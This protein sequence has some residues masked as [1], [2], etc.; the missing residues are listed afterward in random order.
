MAAMPLL[1]S[2]WVTAQAAVT[3]VLPRIFCP[4]RKANHHNTQYDGE[5]V[6]ENRCS[7]VETQVLGGVLISKACGA[8]GAIQA[9]IVCSF[10]TDSLLP[11]TRLSDSADISTTYEY[12]CSGL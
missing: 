4:R 12:F 10:G 9:V 11:R 7:R 5:A 6:T 8:T 1:E 3:A 2:T